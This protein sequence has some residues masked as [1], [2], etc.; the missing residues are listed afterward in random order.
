MA[1]QRHV[2][3]DSGSCEVDKAYKC[4]M[5]WER[6]EPLTR[7]VYSSLRRSCAEDVLESLHLEP[8]NLITNDL[9]QVHQVLRAVH[10]KHINNSSLM[11][12][13]SKQLDK[14]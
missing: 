14:G 13:N 12:L 6:Q 8:K 7:S 1:V 5:F 4:E 2:S 11:K 3:S 9:G 10:H